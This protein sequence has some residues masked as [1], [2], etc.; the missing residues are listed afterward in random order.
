MR[1]NQG[2]R[3]Q[4]YFV[5][6]VNFILAVT[7]SDLEPD[8]H[9]PH[10]ILVMLTDSVATAMQANHVATVTAHM[11]SRGSSV[12]QLDGSIV[13]EAETNFERASETN[14]TTAK[15]TEGIDEAETHFGING[16][17]KGITDILWDNALGVGT[18]PNT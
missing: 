4:D 17:Q 5:F 14:R 8:V 3:V 7:R 15:G 13:A 10:R 6:L 9:C 2:I 16:R 11:H 12:E 18:T 1:E